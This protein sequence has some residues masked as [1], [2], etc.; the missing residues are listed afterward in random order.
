MFSFDQKIDELIRRLGAPEGTTNARQGDQV[1]NVHYPPH[2][3]A[4]LRTRLPK[5]MA[6][7]KDQSYAPRHCSLLALMEKI[8]G[9]NGKKIAL[10]RRSEA[11]QQSHQAFT[12]TLHSILAN[13]KPG[14][15]LD[16]ES[17]I[18]AAIEEEI[19]AAASKPNGLLLITDIEMAHPLLRVSA[20][21]QV[22][23][24]RFAVPT[25]FFYPGERGNIGDNPS[26]LGVYPSDGNYRST[27]I[28]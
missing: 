23:Q 18:V 21:E 12:D 3:W 10:L 15:S 2:L 28:Y 20:F 13:K 24:G 5:L 11:R 19:Q 26:Y 27:H 9:D 7:L 4:E 1:F 25:V 16:L 14:E 22:L 17:P 8:F 6:R